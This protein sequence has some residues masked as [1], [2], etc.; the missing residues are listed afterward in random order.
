MYRNR[1]GPVGWLSP[2]SGG[3]VAKRVERKTPY[4]T[5]REGVSG[6]HR[7]MVVVLFR[8]RDSDR[9]VWEM[10][11]WERTSRSRLRGGVVRNVKMK[12]EKSVVTD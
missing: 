12:N 2:P 11:T 3:T 6:S 9:P 1:L 5:V 8:A 10:S 4:E 7:G